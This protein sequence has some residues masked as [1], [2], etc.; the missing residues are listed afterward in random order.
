MSNYNKKEVDL[1]IKKARKMG[2]GEDF[3]MSVAEAAVGTALSIGSNAAGAAMNYNYN[4]KSQ[5]WQHEYNKENMYLNERWNRERAEIANNYA[6]ENWQMQNEYN[7]PEKQRQ[8]LE[9]AGLSVGLMYGG[10]GS[11]GGTQMGSPASSGTGGVPGAAA[12][13]SSLGHGA[14]AVRLLETL[15]VQSEIDVNKSIAERNRAEA[16]NLGEGTQTIVET[17]PLIV[18]ELKEKGKMQWIQNSFDT[19]MHE[20]EFENDKTKVFVHNQYGSIQFKPDSVLTQAQV[21]ALMEA[22]ARANNLEANAEY[23]RTRNSG[24]WAEMANALTT[25][26]AAWKNADANEKRLVIDG[27]LASARK[28]EAEYNTGETMN[29]KQIIGLVA[30]AVQAGVSIAQV[31]AEFKKAGALEDMGQAQQ[32]QANKPAPQENVLYRPEQTGHGGVIYK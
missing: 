16:R 11:T 18:A 5:E 8:R 14:Q 29:A 23:T 13:Q 10:A 7:T 26:E 24:Y 20:R 1:F 21:A 3:G 31:V 15:A 4:R 6:R 22:T 2:L 19:Y 30:Q 32:T 28:M 12:P 25:A 27:V 17:R 9:D